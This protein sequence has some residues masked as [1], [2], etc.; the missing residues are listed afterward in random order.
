MKFHTKLEISW[1]QIRG[2]I[3]DV[4]GTLY[5]KRKLQAMMFLE[6][7]GYLFQNKYAF[8]DIKIISQFRK[9]REQLASDETDNVL[10]QQIIIPANDL[11]LSPQVVSAVIDEWIYRRPLKYMFACRFPKVDTFFNVLKRRG[12]KIGIFSDYPV[13]NKLSSLGLCADAIC[14]SLESGLGKLKPHTLGLETIVKRLSLDK[15][16]CL[17]IGDRESRDGTC[18]HR[19]GMP[20]L[21]CHGHDFYRQILLQF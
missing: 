4:D 11:S 16:D 17:F 7:C 10:Q 6:L 14:Y 8:R 18:A 19:F 12:I 21:Y 1:E 3:F 15:S 2:V 13:E 9:V 5:N 20:F